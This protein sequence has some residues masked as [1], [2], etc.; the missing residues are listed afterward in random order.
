MSPTSIHPSASPSTPITSP[1][2]SKSNTPN[3]HPYLIHTTSSSILTRSNSSPA[4]PLSAINGGHRSSRSM[5]SLNYVLEGGSGGGGPSNQTGGKSE[6]QKLREKEDRRRSMDSP[7]RIRPGVKRSGTL[8]DF[9]VREKGRDKGKKELELPLNPKQWT[10]SE[11]A[12]Y[13]ASTLRTGGPDGTGQT[14]PAPLVKDIESWVLAQ[15][16][17]GREFMRG[18]ADGWGNTTRPPPF[19]PLLQSIARK[20]RRN[21]LQGR[22]DSHAF[23]LNTT[24]TADP[25]GS[26]GAGSVLM[27]EDEM[28]SDDEDAQLPTGVKKM[29]IALDARSSASETDTSASGDDEVMEGL[30]AQLTGESVGER[31]KKW[32]EKASRVRKVSDVS[33]NGSMADVE[34][35]PRMEKRTLRHSSE[36]R[37]DEEEDDAKGG[38][39]KAPPV[40]APVLTTPSLDGLTP[41]PP[42]TSYFP[43]QSPA[44]AAELSGHV[45]P[46]RPKEQD[47]FSVTPT[48]EHRT[49]HSTSGLGI[50]TPSP[51]STPSKARSTVADGATGSPHMSNMAQHVSSGSKPYATLGRASSSVTHEDGPS[52]PTVRS[53]A[54]SAYDDEEDEEGS[55]PVGSAATGTKAWQDQELEGSR[56]TTARR[57]TLRPSKVQ[58]VFERER[59]EEGVE[60]KMEKLMERIKELESRLESVSTIPVP[61][62]TPSNAVEAVEDKKV[63]TNVVREVSILDLLG[64]GAGSGSATDKSNDGLPRRVRELPAYLFLVGVGVGAVMVRVFFRRAR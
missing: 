25:D 54:L 27:E 35:S 60:E 21:S 24:S 14:L 42:Y 20:L 31:W 48:P 13:L 61:T 39:I 16:V 43:D 12:Q 15:R 19:L 50:L 49:Y 17:S 22:H 36:E 3:Y 2:K 7:S 9:L 32:E 1:S 37:S 34:S 26:F 4:Q 18:S 44:P 28:A 11:L 55:M 30:K 64:F 53:I 56:W 41:P 47:S 45:T 5:S 51:E 29:I 46:R 8:P 10:P 33:S 62:A 40:A 6:E 23:P 59:N 58:N 52:Y 63:A 57:V 38:T